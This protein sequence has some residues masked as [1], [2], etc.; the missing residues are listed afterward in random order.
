MSSRK[1]GK[2]RI[3]GRLSSKGGSGSRIEGQIRQLMGIVDGNGD[4]GEKERGWIRVDEF[5]WGPS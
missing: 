2:M 5:K 1:G 3:G 4:D